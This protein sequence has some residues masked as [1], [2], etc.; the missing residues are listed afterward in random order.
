MHADYIWHTVRPLLT[1]HL[2][3]IGLAQLG[4]LLAPALQAREPWLVSETCHSRLRICGGW[5]KKALKDPIKA[6]LISDKF[7]VEDYLLHEATNPKRL[8]SWSPG[9]PDP[10]YAQLAANFGS[11]L[12]SIKRTEIELIRCVYMPRKTERPQLATPLFRE[13][14]RVAESMEKSARF[15]EPIV[16][17]RVASMYLNV[18]Q[19][20][21]ASLPTWE[22]TSENL[23]GPETPLHA[24][25]YIRIGSQKIAL[26]SCL[27]GVVEK[28]NQFHARMKHCQQTFYIL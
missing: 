2:P 24:E 23:F 5:I 8:F 17:L 1:H 20:Y 10:N 11:H 28:W 18:A 7:E 9:E 27:G 22:C 14:L 6:G 4:R 15:E 19:L 13:T 21:P 26:R 3:I 16:A 12:D 25:A